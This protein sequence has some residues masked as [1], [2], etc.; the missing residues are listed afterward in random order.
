MKKKNIN[1]NSFI[2][3]ENITRDDLFEVLL[4]EDIFSFYLGEKISAGNKINSPFREDNVPSFGFYYRRDKSGI[5]MF[6]DLATPDCG[7]AIV[8]VMKMFDLNYKQALFKIAYDFGLSNV[9]ITSDRK[10]IISSQRIKKQKEATKIGIKKRNWKK[11]DAE[12]WKSFGIT[13]KTL[14]KYNVYPVSHIFYNENIFAAE[15]YAYAYLEFKDGLVSYKIYQ[16]FSKDFKWSG[17]VDRSIHQGY[18]QLPK[19]G[20]ILIITK[21]LKDVMSIRDTIRIPSTALQSES[22]MMKQSVMDEYKSRFDQVYCLFDND[23]PGRL[24]TRHF[25]EEYNIPYLFMPYIK[26]VTDFSDYA[27]VVSPQRAGEF[28]KSQLKI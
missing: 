20:K 5:L 14:K 25:I 9:E 24:F 8:F 7:D 1:L 27:K 13:K 18:T 21:S 3:N 10:Q 6:N 26:K 22:I 11:H 12:F 16:P 15:K 23:K 28:L 17:N 2:Y 19:K 4:Q